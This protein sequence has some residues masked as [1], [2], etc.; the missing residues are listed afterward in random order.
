MWNITAPCGTSQ[1]HVE[2]PSSSMWNITAA[3]CGTSQQ[4]HV[5][6]PSSSMW[7]IPA[8][9]CGTSQQLHVEHPSSSMW[10]IPAAPCGT[11][12]QLHVEHHTSSM[13]NITAAPSEREHVRAELV[14]K[15]LDS[16][17][18]KSNQFSLKKQILGPESE[19][20]CE[21]LRLI[22]HHRLRL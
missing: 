6:H 2:H 7:N 3:P 18:Q 22:I 9:P 8:A 20:I 17:D 15:C 5:E 10:N 16:S 13:W 21:T 1:L 14:F 11:S 19:T 4:L 12:Q